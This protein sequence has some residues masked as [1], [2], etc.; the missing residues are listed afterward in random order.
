M[1]KTGRAYRSPSW[2]LHFIIF[3]I[4]SAGSWGSAQLTSSLGRFTFCPGENVTVSCNLSSTQNH[5][6][7][8]VGLVEQR[9][10]VP[11]QLGV[12]VTVANFIFCVTSTGDNGAVTGSTL[13]FVAITDVIANGTEIR[14]NNNVETVPGRQTEM[15]TV[16]IFGELIILVLMYSVII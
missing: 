13:T 10:L 8:V 16:N 2:T 7:D 6:W 3:C 4:I 12:A 9:V 15:E 1:I 11:E 14:C 5:V